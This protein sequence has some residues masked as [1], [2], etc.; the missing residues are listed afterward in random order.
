MN[1][2]YNLKKAYLDNVNI[3]REDYCISL[4]TQIINDVAYKKMTR[5]DQNCPEKFY[6]IENVN[7]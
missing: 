7:D 3:L 1:D 6:K 5:D 4:G 2:Y